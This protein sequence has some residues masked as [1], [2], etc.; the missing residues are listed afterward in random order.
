MGVPDWAPAFLAIWQRP[1]K[2]TVADAYKEFSDCCEGPTPSIF[3]VRRFLAKMA[4]ADREAGRETGNALL[5]RRPHKRRS[6]DELWPTDVYTA[7]GTT[8][9]AEIQHPVHGRPFKPEVTFILDVATRRCVGMPVIRARPRRSVVRC[10]CGCCGAP[11]P[12]RCIGKSRPNSFRRS[13]T[14]RPP[15][16]FCRRT[17]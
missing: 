3:A 2:P 9:D 5:K 17:T 14:G 1:Q 8:F 11:K 13:S 6:T 4:D 16:A 7:D 12:R 10:P 15:T